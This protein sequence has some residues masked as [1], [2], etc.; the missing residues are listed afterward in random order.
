[1]KISLILV[2]L[3]CG[4]STFSPRHSGKRLL[5][6]IHSEAV[7]SRESVKIVPRRTAINSNKRS[8]NKGLITFLPLI[9]QKHEAIIEEW[10]GKDKLEDFLLD[11]NYLIAGDGCSLILIDEKPPFR[12]FLARDNGK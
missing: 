12:I 5:T 8:S 10:D 7:A 4:C 1:M 6:T 11:S 3:L 9:H 2:L